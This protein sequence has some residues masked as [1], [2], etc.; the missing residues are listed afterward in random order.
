MLT[1]TGQVKLL[2]NRTFS[3]WGVES[4][5][6]LYGMPFAL[7]V[8]SSVFLR[9][10]P[11]FTSL[12]KFHSRMVSFF[13]AFALLWYEGQD[14]VVIAVVSVSCFLFAV[15]LAWGA[16][17]AR[18]KGQYES[19]AEKLVKKTER[20]GRTVKKK[21]TGTINMV[22]SSKRISTVMSNGPLAQKGG[23]DAVIDV[24]VAP[25]PPSEKVAVA[26]A[27]SVAGNCASWLKR[28]LFK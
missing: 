23:G 28:T 20:V 4:L 1:P 6:I 10:C 24:Q 3:R 19:Y 25:I 16:T 26:M 15:I 13:A 11:S 22:G 8:W 9:P 5:A 18:E 12:L 27:G 14:N 17:A 7:L 2:A 21:V